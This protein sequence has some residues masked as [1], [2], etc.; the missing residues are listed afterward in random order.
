MNS[1][2]VTERFWPK[3]AV[4][5][6]DDCWEWQAARMPHGYGAFRI[7]GRKGKTHA[8]HRWLWSQLNGEV[9]EDMF[10]CHHCDNPPCCNPRHLFLGTHADNMRDMFAKQRRQAALGEQNGKSKATE[11]LVRHIR[12]TYT[13]RRGELK[14]LIQTTGLHKNTLQAILTRRTWRHI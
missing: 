3:V 2:S 5:G 12:A 13:G 6:P 9:P 1:P 14:E 11:N 4:G 10:I 8:A 7:G